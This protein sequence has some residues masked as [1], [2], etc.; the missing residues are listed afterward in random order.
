MATLNEYFRSEAR[1]FLVSLERS[2]QRAPGPDAAELHH[3]VRGLR[4]TAQM[5]RENRVFDVVSAFEAATR[6]IADGALTWSDT[7]AARARD[8][9]SDLRA[10]LERTED[11]EQLDERV[12]RA[13]ARWREADP[14]ASS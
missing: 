7:V 5:A 14:A 4:G 2:L 11:D 12:N 8:T 13:A 6:S 3:A 1:D 10:L 9:V